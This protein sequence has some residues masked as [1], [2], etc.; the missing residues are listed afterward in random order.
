MSPASTSW[1]R[2][3][4]SALVC[5]AAIPSAAKDREYS[6]EVPNK[7]YKIWEFDT[8]QGYSMHLSGIF[9]DPGEGRRL[10]CLP[11]E[12]LDSSLYLKTMN[13]QKGWAYWFADQ[14]WNFFVA[15]LPGTE[16]TV[17]SPNPDIVKLTEDAVAA[18]YKL[19]VATQPRAFYAQG[20]GAAFCIKLRSTTPNAIP[21]AILLDPIGTKGMQPKITD[22]VEQVASWDDSLEEHLWVK[23][24]LG[25]RPGKL[26]PDSDLGEEGFRALM[27]H[28]DHNAPPFWA[29]VLTGLQ[30]W[31]EI[32]NPMNI[33]N[34]PVLLVRG[35][36]PTP[37]MDA[38]REAVKAWLSENGASIEE[39]DL[40]KEGPPGLSNLPMAGAKADSVA[41][42]FMEWLKNLPNNPD[43]H[44][45]KPQ[46]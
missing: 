18:T 30:T 8:G 37:E 5:L 1:I 19:G 13:G 7:D 35:P 38:R 2:I 41:A 15:D 21:A 16:K 3:F 29:T 23:W 32:K 25:P 36:H 20:L 12:D 46:P 24:G 31:M 14:H 44:A 17:P 33:A 9:W 11:P 39:M 26:Y 34:W 45:P 4:A 43:F 10:A 27:E 28:Y 40:G 22:T 6:K 42:L